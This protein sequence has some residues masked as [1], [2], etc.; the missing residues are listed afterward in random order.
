MGNEDAGDIKAMTGRCKVNPP[1]ADP[2]A[3][4]SWN[5]WSASRTNTRFQRAA[6]AK[7]PPSGVSKL[8]LK[9]AFGI[10]AG[11]EIYSQPTAA[12]GRLFFGGDT[13]FVYSLDAKTGCSYWSFRAD[14]GVRSVV[15]IGAIQGHPGV[16]Y[17]AYFGDQQNR[18]YAVDAQTGKLLWKARIDVQSRSHMTAS[19][20]FYKGK[21]FVPTAAGETLVGG[22]SAY[23]CCKTRGAVSA[24]DASTGK[25]LWRHEAIAAAAQPTHK[26]GG[27]VQ[28]WGPAGASVWNAPTV[29]E[30]RGLIYFGTGNGYTAPAAETTDSIIALEIETGKE[31]WHHQHFS[32]DAYI[33]GCG[34]TS[35]AGGN[36]PQTLGPDWD[37]GGASAMLVRSSS[38][39][40]L[41][42]A[43]KG[44]V[45]ISLDPD[46]KGKLLW[47]TK[48]F[49]GAPPYA[50]GLI[51]FGGAVDGA[52]GYFPLN[53]PGGGVAAV[54]LSD[55]KR[56]WTT[57]AITKEKSRGQSAAASAIP[58]VVF[59]G[60]WDG[61]L[62]ALS[63]TGGKVIWEFDTRRDFKTVNGVPGKGGSLGAPGPI[64][65][66]G[67]LF[68]GSGYT[69]TQSGYP[70][71]VILAFAP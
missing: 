18:V 3:R 36:C 47:E 58:G 19:V 35:S 26:N 22:N 4:P 61:T 66:D 45:A 54:R 11:S 9:W 15:S 51:V 6:E 56:L 25:V 49:E 16:K 29:D 24:L 32:G 31:V 30:K 33:S 39:D 21:L 44:G 59:S 55:G 7:L 60:A 48:L 1:L 43:G 57:G 17:A 14:S 28:M 13:G 67:M 2:A 65:V 34:P 46:Q 69:G 5:G 8:K 10:P 64:I 23:E 20:V 37:F 53:Q 68:V 70:G 63:T 71:N 42:A 62:R 27:G 12:S 52:N 40:R 41:I 50:G 38:G